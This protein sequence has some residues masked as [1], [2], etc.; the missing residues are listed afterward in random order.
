MTV[1]PYPRIDRA[2]H[3]IRRHHQ[4]PSETAG[5]RVAVVHPLAVAMQAAANAAHGPRLFEELVDRGRLAF[6][7]GL[8]R[9]AQRD[10]RFGALL[11]MTMSTCAEW[12]P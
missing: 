3:Q 12:R 8:E 7:G 11:G 9:E 10:P 2:R 5:S 1:R 6:F 4:P